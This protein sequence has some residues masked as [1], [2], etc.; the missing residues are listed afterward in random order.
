MDA[1]VSAAVTS[2]SQ[3]AYRRYWPTVIDG[4]ISRD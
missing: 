4:A 1:S 2:L 3:A